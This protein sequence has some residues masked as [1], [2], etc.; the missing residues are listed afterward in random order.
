MPVSFNRIPG[1]IRV[2]FFYAEVNSGL[3]Y[4]QGNSKLLLIG[5]MVS[6]GSAAANVP[7]LVSRPGPEMFGVGSMLAE[8]VYAARLNSA[9]GEIWALP[10]ADPS[11]VAATKTITVAGTITA[12]TLVFYVCGEKVQIPVL[13]TDTVTT[14]AAAMAAAINAGYTGIDG[15]GYSFPYTA[16][17]AAGVVTATARNVGTQGNFLSIDKDLIGDEGPLAALLTIATG[18]TG[19]G[20]PA[21]TTGLAAL[22]DTEFDM[23]AMPYSDATSL[24]AV[25]D[26]LADGGGRWDPMSQLYGHCVTVCFDTLSNLA[27]LGTGRND[28]HVSIMG[29]AN[30]P[31]P[32]HRWAAALGGQV[33]AHKNLGFSLTEA[34]EISRP[35]QT[36]I[37]KGIKPPRLKIDQWDRIERQ[38]LYYDGISAFTV[39]VDGQ[40]VLDR[41]ITT[42]RLNAW[43]Q[44]DT[45]FLDIETLYQTAYGIRFLRQQVSQKHAR[46][47][48]APDN[49][50]GLQGVTT[51]VDLKA[52]LIHGYS[53]LCDAGVMK[54]LALFASSIVVE[55]SSDP[56]RAN[57]FLPFDVM[58]Q[59]RIFAA[60]VETSLNR[61]A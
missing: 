22:G 1:N 14:I 45:T 15:K 58:N 26:F 20:V 43:S 51:P 11:G 54:N 31:S 18:V 5:Q 24:N 37:L 60:N 3:S 32:P 53:Q 49:P 4:Y 57:C 41:L 42:Y 27:T 28:P 7:V 56:N 48:L 44:P 2:P 46:D 47:A 29:V 39:S 52:D 17:S 19:T 35:M 40:V 25:R 33:Q 9:L 8:M 23:I 12:G 59:L 61:A 10:I 6:G 36:L 16:T 21:L 30:S 38:T 50:R 55:Q 34:V 13:S